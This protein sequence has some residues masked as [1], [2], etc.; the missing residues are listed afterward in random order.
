MCHNS[1][2]AGAPMLGN[3]AQWKDRAKKGYRTLV[4]NTWKGLNGM[5]AKGLCNDCTKKEIGMAVQ[6]M[7]DSI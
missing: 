1:G 4:N 5:P 6:Y 3:K 7:L 2:V